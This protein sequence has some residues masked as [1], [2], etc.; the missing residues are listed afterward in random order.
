[1]G[2]KT[3]KAT[4]SGKSTKAASSPKLMEY[5]G[6]S[7]YRIEY[8]VLMDL[9]VQIGQSIP[10][11]LDTARTP[12][13]FVAEKGYIIQLGLANRKITKLPKSIGLLAK[14]EVLDLSNN[15]LEQIPDTICDL[16][17]L[18][19]LI[20]EENRLLTLPIKLNQLESV[21][22]LYLFQ[23]QIAELPASITSLKK[24]QEALFHSNRLKQL[25]PDLGK[26]IA[27]KRLGLGSNQLLTIPASIGE[28]K[29]LEYLSIEENLLRQLPEE[30][31]M[32]NNLRELNLFSNPLESLPASLIKL[33][34]LQKL[35]IWGT[36][37]TNEKIKRDLSPIFETLRMHGCEIIAQGRDPK[38][39][40]PI[41]TQA[42]QKIKTKISE[43]EQN[44]LALDSLQAKASPELENF[45][46]EELQTMLNI[47]AVGEEPARALALLQIEEKLRGNPIPNTVLDI[48][49]SV[50][51]VDESPRIRALALRVLFHPPSLSWFFTEEQKVKIR[52]ALEHNKRDGFEG[53]IALEYLDMDD[54]L[55]FFSRKRNP[56]E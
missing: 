48:L 2:K 10:P 29:D 51:E 40:A 8:S 22:K 4:K 24:L 52:R 32:L 5:E 6:I 21:E 26:L 12:Y 55:Q 25:P 11:I 13:G 30:I 35:K 50:N 3:T 36:N 23:N 20:L 53:D 34:N 31:G 28:L 16:K 1:M 44:K 56:N 47:L 49:L 19:M 15:Q 41:F 38:A 17:T 14:I 39:T 46:L 43:N 37:I 27:L 42:I 7:L 45:I 54:K 33:S 9:E 18:K